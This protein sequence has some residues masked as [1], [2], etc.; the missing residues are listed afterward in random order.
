MKRLERHNGRQLVKVSV[1]AICLAA[2]LGCVVRAAADDPQI[3]AE[4]NRA[5]VRVGD[6]IVLSVQLEGFSKRAGAP[7]VPK[8]DGFEIYDSGR[9]TNISWVNGKLSSSTTHTYQLVARRAG[10]YTLGPITVD[11]KGRTYRADP[12]SLQV[13]AGST[14]PAPATPGGTR[15]TPP[16][17]GQTAEQ[18]LFA[19][20]EID[21]RE[22]YLDEQVVLRFLLYQRADI[23]LHEIADFQAPTTEGFWREDLGP[24]RDYRVEIEGELYQVRE[25]SW[26]LFPTKVGELEIGSGSIVCHV[27]ERSR[28]RG[29]FSDFFGRGLF[30]RPVPLRTEP[31]RVRVKALP[32]D[33]RPAGFSGTVGTY[34]IDAQFDT[35]EARQGDPLALTVTVRGAGHVQTIAVPE[36]PEWEGL[37]VFDS[38]EAVSVQKQDDRVMG[39]KTFTQVLIPTRTGSIALDPIRLS[40]FDPA[41]KRYRTASTGPLQIEVL[42][43]EAS[44]IG[45]GSA[46]V[47]AVGD[48][49][50]YIQTGLLGNLRPKHG[51][52]LGLSWLIH[53]VPIGLVVAAAWL[54][55]RR[56]VLESDP[57]L[58]RR[59]QALKTARDRLRRLG[60][61]GP[62]SS[63][64]ADL[65][66][67]VE[68]YLSDWLDVEVRGLRRGDLENTLVGAGV[69]SDLATQVMQLLDWSD[70]VRFG[71]GTLESTGERIR[72]AD[73]L[74]RSL[75]EE[76]RKSSLG[77]R[78]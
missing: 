76:L 10:N 54:R 19:R 67:V 74:L 69:S 55:N 39:E 16:P 59:A 18:G 45:S 68:N 23:R 25:I 36:W 52:G 27:P 66:D 13:V 62:T 60:E 41:Q 7:N 46:D 11:D 49:I 64:A 3:R 37:R 5:Q 70:S 57:S 35:P 50:L 31:M 47:L 77:V 32:D 38:G 40:F 75:E 43:A 73:P 61:H 78:L 44:S 20:V 24:Q 65:T 1:L 4:V 12:L 8:P 33:G 58:A 15:E 56:M 48:D 63:A 28:R 14:Q 17:S 29:G 21:K 26:A 22:A 72:G 6:V 51:G 53:L 42:P 2:V 9:S 34:R 30:S 71:V